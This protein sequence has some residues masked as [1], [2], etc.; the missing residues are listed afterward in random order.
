VRTLV[1]VAFEAIKVRAFPELKPVLL[2]GFD[3]FEFLNDCKVIDWWTTKSAQGFYIV[4][5]GI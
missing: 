1:D 3:F 5:L 4:Y 2:I